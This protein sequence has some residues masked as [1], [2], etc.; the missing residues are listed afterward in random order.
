MISSGVGDLQMKLNKGDCQV[1]ELEAAHK[2][3]ILAKSQAVQTLG[4][5]TQVPWAQILKAGAAQC[6]QSPLAGI[7]QGTQSALARDL[8]APAQASD[9]PEAQDK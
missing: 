8:A 2:R 6:T 4:Q 1:D 5:T 9:T 3:V 7:V